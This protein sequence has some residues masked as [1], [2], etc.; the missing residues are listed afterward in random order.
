MIS[1]D[2][3]LIIV[4]INFVIL[5][6]ILSKVLYKPLTSFLDKREKQ[7]KEDL[8]SAKKSRIQAEGL[9]KKQEKMLQEA[10]QEARKIRDDATAYAKKEEENIIQDAYKKRDAILE[11]AKKTVEAEVQKAKRQIQAEIGEL[12]A[13]L[14]D[15]LIKKKLTEKDD[16]KLIDSLIASELQNAGKNK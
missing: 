6:L 14:T 10:K 3:T 11:E 15:R 9:L 16:L 12:V 1:I 7:I 4:I 5:L 13:G 8:E 2:Y